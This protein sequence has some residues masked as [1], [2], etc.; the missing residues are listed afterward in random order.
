[1]NVPIWVEGKFQKISPAWNFLTKFLTLRITDGNTVI[2][3]CSFAALGPAF[4]SM[5]ENNRNETPQCFYRLQALWRGEL[6]SFSC[7]LICHCL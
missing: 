3:M 7:G 2:S 1:M 4:Y 5:L 6:P